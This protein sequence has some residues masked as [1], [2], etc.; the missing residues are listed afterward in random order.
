MIRVN[1]ASGEHSIRRHPRWFKSMLQDAMTL[2]R[3][4]WKVSDEEAW[5]Y[6][7]H[8]DKLVAAERFSEILRMT[9]AHAMPYH[10]E[11]LPSHGVEF[12]NDD[13]VVVQ[14]KL[15]HAGEK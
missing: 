11:G 10:K 2:F 8:E 7:L 3:D 4:E 12:A 9:G 1:M 5:R 13:E 6:I 14:Y 15:K